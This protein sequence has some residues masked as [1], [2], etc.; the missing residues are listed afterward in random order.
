MSTHLGFAYVGRD[1]W[2]HGCLKV[3]PPP[4]LRALANLPTPGDC[5]ESAKGGLHASN[6]VGQKGSVTNKQPRWAHC[7]NEMNANQTRV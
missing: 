5:G 2:I 3:R 6:P 4:H 7:T 1:I